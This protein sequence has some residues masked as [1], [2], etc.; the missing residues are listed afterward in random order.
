MLRVEPLIPP[1][2]RGGNECHV[3]VREV[4]NGIIYILSTGCQAAGGPE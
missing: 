4:M 1:T 3:D 2:K